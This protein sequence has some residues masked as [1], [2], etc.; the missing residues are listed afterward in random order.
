MVVAETVVRQDAETEH[1]S[2]WR[3]DGVT[4]HSPQSAEKQALL[5][6]VSYVQGL[7]TDLALLSDTA[8]ALV[9]LVA[10][11]RSAAVTC[12]WGGAGG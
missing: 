9:D 6:S 2:S 7:C 5:V 3:S 8:Q 10:C 1:D 11:C 4:R 12:Y